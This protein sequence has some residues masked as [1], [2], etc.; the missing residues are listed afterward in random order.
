MIR[1]PGQGLTAAAISG[2]VRVEG[3]LA[4]DHGDSVGIN[5]APGASRRG[6]FVRLVSV[7]SRVAQ[8][9]SRIASQ[10]TLWGYERPIVVG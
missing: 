6:A 10:R 3:N 2:V 9:I 7:L 5:R 8:S 4:V 1:E